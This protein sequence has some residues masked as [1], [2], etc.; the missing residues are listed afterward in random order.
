M[1][2]DDS[3][4]VPRS[5]AQAPDIDSCVFVNGNGAALHPGQLV[6][7]RV[8]DYQNYDLIAQIPQEKRRSLKVVSK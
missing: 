3:E 1:T 5:G 6:N 2:G 7:V 4:R 8:T